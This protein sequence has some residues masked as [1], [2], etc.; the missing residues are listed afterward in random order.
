MPALTPSRSPATAG[1]QPIEIAR[2]S[3]LPPAF[4][5]WTPAFAGERH[6]G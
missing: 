6:N 2:G 3:V 4:R 1:V 5:D